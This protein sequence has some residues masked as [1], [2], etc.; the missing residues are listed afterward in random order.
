VILLLLL[1][2]TG[3]TGAEAQRL[4]A[5]EYFGTAGNDRAASVSADPSGVYVAGHVGG[6]LP[7]QTFAGTEDAFVRKLDPAGNE[8]WT[9]QFGTVFMDRAGAIA[10]HAGVV[11]T[12]GLT[13][14]ALPGQVS[15]G[16]A[17]AFVRS[18][19]A[20]GNELWTR[21]FGTVYPDDAAGVAAD[22]G[23]VYVAGNTQGA[24]PDQVAAGGLSDAFVR[25]YDRAGNELWTRQFGT[26]G[27]DFVAGV[28]ADA[29]GVYVAGNTQGALPGQV[30]AGG[31]AD[32]F[33]RKLDPAG[34]ELWT[35]QFGTP[36][37]DA[38]TGVSV[39]AGHVYV[40][41]YTFGALEAPAGSFDAFVRK[42]DP[43]GNELWTRQF[44]SAAWDQAN[45]V[46][47]DDG[48]LSVAGQTEGVLPGQQSAGLRD[49]F[50][51]RYNATGDELWTRQFGTERI[52]EASGLAVANGVTYAGGAS[53]NPVIGE[54][55]SANFEAFLARIA[56]PAAAC[57]CSL[58]DGAAT[59]QSTAEP[60][61]GPVELGVR[62][63][64]D[65]AGQVTGLR[66]YKGPQNTE[67]HTGS[68]WTAGGQLLGRVTFADETASG[69]QQADFA[70]PVPLAAGA[71]YVASYHAP[72][73]R[74][75]QDEGYFAAAGVDRP[76]LHAPRDGAGGGNGLY[77][78][79]PAGT[80]PDQTFDAA[81]YWVDVVFTTDPSPSPTPT[82]SSTPTATP[83]PTP[84]PTATPSPSP[85]STPTPTAT[86]SPSSTPTPT[87]TPTPTATP[88]PE[89]EL[90]TV[91]FDD[92]SGE[93]QVLSGQSPEGVIDWGS[94]QWWHS[95]PWG[96]FATKSVSFNG[97][98]LRSGTFTFV[99]PARLVKLDAYNGG[100]SEST[101]TLSCSGQ[102]TRTAK[103]GAKQL[104]TILVDWMPTCT[105]VTIGS[106][107]GWDTNFDNLVVAVSTERQARLR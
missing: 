55:G 106:S 37:V 78:Y 31:Q 104:A 17:D 2:P 59:P 11:Y 53:G 60:D 92:R 16:Q 47:A 100:H 8:L 27:S 97:P 41:G 88:T 23:G 87:P 42:L 35:R 18:Y 44:G 43:A 26:P 63:R 9:R 62:F 39:G 66:F 56:A 102:P 49:A 71:D 77:R 80:F 5:I 85:S 101:I 32:A 75:S 52:D 46:T 28:A 96:L 86:P 73:G 7:G 79:G 93:S 1:A 38:V 12:A 3:P 4:E 64:A 29:G 81:N 6:A 103:L 65:V 99:A 72:Q 76:P 83:T 21:Q 15:A 24:L 74:Y 68:L 58:W 20:A 95:R 45:G 69:W 50:V 89:P 48:G 67:P 22:A 91:T 34:N 25:K 82:P 90:L 19:D 98:G 54:G 94:N 13:G 40:V 33:V 70:A 36:T 10:A 14:G 30:A 57:P 84:T 105:V 51:R 107:N 61:S